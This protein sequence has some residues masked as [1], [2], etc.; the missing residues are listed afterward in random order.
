MSCSRTVGSFSAVRI[1]LW[2]S[3]RVEDLIDNRFLEGA[4]A[5]LARRSMSDGGAATMMPPG[6]ADENSWFCLGPPTVVSQG[7]RPRRPW[8][9]AQGTFAT[10]SRSILFSPGPSSYHDKQVNRLSGPATPRRSRA[11]SHGT[12]SRGKVGSA[13]KKISQDD[14]PMYRRNTITIAS[15]TSNEGALDFASAVLEVTATNP[16]YNQ[17]A[18]RIKQVSGHDM[19][20]C[21]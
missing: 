12:G 7:R 11:R 13:W 4:S 20:S 15:I 19:G 8:W 9:P 10:F 6:F 5:S 17:P 14:T 3:T 1:M 16:A 2:Y 18:L 21:S